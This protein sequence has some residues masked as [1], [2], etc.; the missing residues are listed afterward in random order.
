MSNLYRLP[1]PE[2][3]LPRVGF[4]RQCPQCGATP[5]KCGKCGHTTTEVHL[6][7]GYTRAHC[8]HWTEADS[9]DSGRYVVDGRY[10]NADPKDPLV[11]LTFTK[12]T[13]EQ[14]LCSPQRRV[15]YGFLWL[16]KCSETGTH[17]HQRCERCRWE[18][19]ALVDGSGAV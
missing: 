15:R 14:R 2:V 6:P 9:D 12:K 8:G 7:P 16:K 17:A 1:V 13:N 4:Y 10:E 3:V 5:V 11:F 19:I 18:G